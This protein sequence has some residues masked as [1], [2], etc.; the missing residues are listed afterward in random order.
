M[1]QLIQAIKKQ[2][3]EYKD[4]LGKNLLSKGVDNIEEFK[5]VHGMAQGLDKSLEIINETIE[6]YKKG[7]IDED[8]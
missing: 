3:K 6:R 8:D 1:E 5:R 7:T 4:N 2:I